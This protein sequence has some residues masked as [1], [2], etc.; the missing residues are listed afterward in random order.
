MRK[1]EGFFKWRI[2]GEEWKEQYH[3]FTANFFFILLAYQ[4]AAA[5]CII[6]NLHLVL[7]VMQVFIFVLLFMTKPYLKIVENA[8]SLLLFLTLILSNFI[9]FT[10]PSNYLLTLTISALMLF[11]LILTIFTT[12]K[13]AKFEILKQCNQRSKVVKEIFKEN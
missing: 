11:H 4:I 12:V 2:N 13:F 1:I 3:K 9:N 8:R 7:L 5:F 6:F 10:A